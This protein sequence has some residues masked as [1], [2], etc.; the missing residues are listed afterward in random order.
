MRKDRIDLE[1]ADNAAPCDLRGLLTGDLLAF[2]T[3]ASCRGSYEAGEQVE[4]CRLAGAVRADDRVNRAF[5]NIERDAI[6]RQIAR[7]RFAKFVR[8]DDGS[9]ARRFA[10]ASRTSCLGHPGRIK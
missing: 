6:D 3:N 7:K 8:L 9:H 2:E 4:A 10:E 5:L 1:R